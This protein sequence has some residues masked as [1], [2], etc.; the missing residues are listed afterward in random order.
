[1]ATKTT[2]TKTSA[3]KTKAAP[4]TNARAAN[5]APKAKAKRTVAPIAKRT[6][7]TIHAPFD[8]I[9][10]KT[11]LFGAGLGAGLGALATKLIFFR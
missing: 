8:N 6:A 2:K 10:M 9:D 11:A 4:K 7:A 1:M 5:V 3:T